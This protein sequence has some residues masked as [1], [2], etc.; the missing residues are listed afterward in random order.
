MNPI[1]ALTHAGDAAQAGGK[2]AALA[3]LAGA[4][5]PV[6][7]GFVVSVQAYEQ[8]VA[9]IAERIER[10]LESWRGDDPRALGQIAHEIR[11]LLAAAA[12]PEALAAA[13]SQAHRALGEPAV[14]VRSSSTD[15]DLPQASFAGQQAT[16]LNVRGGDQIV[17]AVKDCWASLFNASAIQYRRALLSVATR[18]RM[19][20]LVQEMVDARAAGVAFTANPVDGDRSKLMIEA[21]FGLGQSVVA[22]EITPDLYVLRKATLEILQRSVNEKGWGYFCAPAPGATVKRP[23]TDPSAQVLSEKEI[24]ALA[25]L[26][27]DIERHCGAPQDI[28]WAIDRRGTLFLLQARPITAMGEALQG[29][30]KMHGALP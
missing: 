28:E 6:P 1:R 17:H 12:M 27:R 16:L 29:A 14:A 3:R 15:E 26:A 22:G 5:F 20:V 25:R 4:G 30:P 9:P 7:H 21:A 11:T 23:V 8:F 13:I 18:P 24:E 19:A 2:A 10:H